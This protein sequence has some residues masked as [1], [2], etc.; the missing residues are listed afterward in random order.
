[1]ILK[2]KIGFLRKCRFKEKNIV[3]CK[4]I[5]FFGSVFV[6]LIVAAVPAHATKTITSPYVT[7]GQASIEWRG[8]YETKGEGDDSWKMRS[9]FSYGFTRYYDLKVSVDSR[10]GDDAEFTDVD[11]ENKFQLAPKGELFI[12]TG[13]RLDYTRALN[14]DADEIG[15]KLLLGKQ[16][17]DVA[18]LLNL[19]AGREIGEDANNEWNYGLAYGASVPVNDMLSIG[20]EWYSDF[21]NFEDGWSA[22]SHLAGP[23][24]YGKAF[25]KVSYQF[26]V[27]AGLSEAAPDALVK[28]TVRY[29]F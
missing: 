29:S 4:N 16:T 23:V 20:G 28:T 25:D 14:G 27:L 1:M 17:G 21:G 13:L 26:G 12:D 7:E 6:S 8:G 22:Q 11:F 19:E 2:N 15:A 9:Q 10:L 5:R 3:S 24:V 18:H